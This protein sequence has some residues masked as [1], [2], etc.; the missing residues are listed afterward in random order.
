MA[1]SDG[2]VNIVDGS[3]ASAS[4][5]HFQGM[6]H[7]RAT[8]YPDNTFSTSYRSELEGIKQVI[9]IADDFKVPS[10]NQTCDNEAAVNNVNTPFKNPT[11]TLSAEADI[12]MAIH[13]MR[14]QSSTKVNLKWVESHQDKGRRKEDLPDEAQL[15][16]EMDQSC[17]NERIT[18]T[19][20]HP[21][22]YPG[23]GAM[24]I[25]D[26][27]WVTTHYHE[28]IQEASLRVQHI[29]W[30]LKK[31]KTRNP[32][33]IEDY[34]NIFWRGIGY[35]RKRFSK[36]DNIRIMKFINGWLN[37][38]RQKGKFKQQPECPG[39]GWPEEDQLH[40]F[41]CKHPEAVT[42]R[43]A[44]ITT[45]GNYYAAHEIHPTIYIPL[46]RMCRNACNAKPLTT[47]ITATPLVTEAVQAQ[48]HLGS[49]FLLRGLLDKRW[50]TAMIDI[51][52]DKPL[53]R[54]TQVYVGLWKVLF[55]SVWNTRNTLLH[56][57][58]SIT[59]RYERATMIRELAEWKRQ[60]A[61]MVGSKQVCLVDYSMQ[62]A[63]RWST[64]LM[65]ETLNLLVTAAHNYKVYCDIN[66]D[67]TRLT[68]YFDPVT[69]QSNDNG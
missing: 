26:D 21:S 35:A 43:N 14:K 64:N 58:D 56:G 41:Q 25:I 67:Q 60:G 15:N 63:I 39:C 8:R 31:Y 65:R 17:G 16:V 34:N 9:E 36:R 33:T 11:Q 47:G 30:F 1:G 50:M 6:Q 57:N 51:E 66:E 62:N 20:Q 27:E 7:S 40:I 13:H 69:N 59:E 38:G 19:I 52:P 4:A 28:R 3:R 29:E 68:E 45:L 5:I 2:S 10:I 46:L 23:S 22:P 32:K 53:V 42:N 12:I 44:A 49:E 18:G 54:M 48:A 24:L 55:R 37:C 61:S